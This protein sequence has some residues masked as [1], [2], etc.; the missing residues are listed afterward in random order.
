MGELNSNL[1]MGENIYRVESRRYLE[2]PEFVT[3]QV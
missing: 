1:S 2:K 3:D